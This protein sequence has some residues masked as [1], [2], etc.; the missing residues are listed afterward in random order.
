[1]HGLSVVPQC[2]NPFCVNNSRGCFALVERRAVTCS[3]SQHRG[4]PASD[5][6]AHHSLD[7]KTG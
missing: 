5:N 6:N 3:L 7:K 2:E 4:D 1:M